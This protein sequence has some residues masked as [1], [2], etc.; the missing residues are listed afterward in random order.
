MPPRPLTGSPDADLGI[1]GCSAA[2]QNVAALSTISTRLWGTMHAAPRIAFSLFKSGNDPMLLAWGRFRNRLELPYHDE[3]VVVPVVHAPPVNTSASVERTVW[4]LFAS[5]NREVARSA[6]AY[7]SFA[8]AREHVA[9]IQSRVDELD[10]HVV[11]GPETGAYGWIMGLDRRAAATCARWY[12]ASVCIEA[13]TSVLGM[14]ET[15]AIAEDWRWTHGAVQR[16]ASNA[17]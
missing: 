2:P 9:A 5:N 17:R 7:G 10:V 8:A 6:R 12:P 14:F 16:S 15:A 13:A 4:R 11:R 1:E 3:P